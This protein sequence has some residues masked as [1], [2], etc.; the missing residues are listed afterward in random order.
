MIVEQDFCEALAEDAPLEPEKVQLVALLS[1]KFGA[2]VMAGS[3]TGF[4]TAQAVS[5]A[6]TTEPKVS[7]VIAITYQIGTHIPRVDDICFS[8]SSSKGWA[9][10]RFL[11]SSLYMSSIES[12]LIASDMAN[13]A[14]QYPPMIW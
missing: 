11:Y 13:K 9:K 3:A 4:A 5:A 12:S 14:S 6:S 10:R 1:N 8:I 2:G 7:L